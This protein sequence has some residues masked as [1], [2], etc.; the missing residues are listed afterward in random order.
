[1]KIVYVVLFLSSAT[2]P[3]RASEPAEAVVLEGH[4]KQVSLVAWASD[5][6]AV[7][8]AGDDRTIR[9][10]NPTM[11]RQTASLLEIAREGY[12]GPVVTLTTDLKVAAVN[13]WGAIAIR[14]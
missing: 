1:M 2:M 5:G 14:N 6:S 12:G 9:L 3:G 13:Y 8:T 4:T 11:G 7:A 10:W